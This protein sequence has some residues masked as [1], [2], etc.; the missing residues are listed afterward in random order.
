[1]GTTKETWAKR[2]KFTL[3]TFCKSAYNPPFFQKGARGIRKKGDCG[4]GLFLSCKGNNLKVVVVVFE[5]YNQNQQ[6]QKNAVRQ[7]ALTAFLL[8]YT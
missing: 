8:V 6:K 5:G 1:M 4:L 2:G 7:L 3:Q